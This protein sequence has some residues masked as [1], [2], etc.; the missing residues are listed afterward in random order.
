MPQFLC[1]AEAA[2]I[3]ICKTRRNKQKSDA[4]GV[5]RKCVQMTA[6][7]YGEQGD[8]SAP[9]E[10]RD[11][12]HSFSTVFGEAGN[13]KKLCRSSRSEAPAGLPSWVE[14]SLRP[15]DSGCGVPRISTSGFFVPTQSCVRLHF[16]AI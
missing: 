8:C 12:F 14:H 6:C 13:I 10:L 15:C 5:S 16:M 2:G 9:Q 1:E 4:A 11:G 7:V 3:R